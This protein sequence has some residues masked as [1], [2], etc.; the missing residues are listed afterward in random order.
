MKKISLSRPI[1]FIGIIA[2]MNCTGLVGCGQR[3]TAPPPEGDISEIATKVVEEL[4]EEEFEEAFGKFNE[5][6]QQAMPYELLGHTWGQ[7]VDQ[8]GEFDRILSLREETIQGYDVIFVTTEFG[9]RIIDIR[10]VFDDEKWIAG[11]F[12]EPARDFSEE[13]WEAPEYVDADGFREEEVTFG[14]TP[15]ILSGTLTLPE[16]NGPHPAVI[17]V[18]GSGPADRDVTIGPNKP[19]KDIAEG[20][21]SRGIAVFRYDKRTYTYQQELE[22]YAGEFTV[23]DEAID[24]A[25]EGIAFLVEHEEIHSEEIFLAGHSLGGMLAPRIARETEELKGLIFLAAPARSLGELMIMQT[26]YLIEHQDENQ[27]VTEE[28]LEELYRQVERIQDPDLPLTTPQEDILGLHAAYWLDLQRYDPLE[29]AR[30][31]S[32]PMI[33]LQGERDYQVTMEDFRL[34]WEVLEDE[35]RSTFRSYPEANHLFM[36]G[37][38]LSLP[39]EY[40]EAN[41]VEEAVI[42]DLADWIAD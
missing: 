23:W 22:E 40:F 31:L 12:F 19:F 2:L 34:W 30:E 14:Q 7:L 42:F 16:G 36:R 15:W 5:E 21:S 18:H 11:L 26:E 38:G 25:L 17:L 37:E 41:H 6:M 39:E 32:L 10:I 20:L 35:S 24:D 13:E 4:T 29:T 8:A 28:E 33:F 1:I 27:E 3:E 9:H